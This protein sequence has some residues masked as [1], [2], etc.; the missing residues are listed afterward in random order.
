MAGTIRMTPQELRDGATF[1]GLRKDECMQQLS[2]MNSK[3]TEVTNNWEGA[4]QNSFVGTFQEM[5]QQIS[6]ALPETVD[7]IMEMLNAAAQTLEETD[8]QL[9]SQLGR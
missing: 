9:D 7:G 2:Q 1:L 3:V 5:Y 6:T 8:A 4:A